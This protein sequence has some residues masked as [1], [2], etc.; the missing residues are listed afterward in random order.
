MHDLL[1]AIKTENVRVPLLGISPVEIRAQVRNLPAYKLV[2][3]GTV[4]SA[5]PGAGTV[6]SQLE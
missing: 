5:L 2:P 1:A 4:N 3:W 6:E